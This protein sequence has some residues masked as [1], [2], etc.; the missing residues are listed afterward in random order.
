MEWLA[1]PR[2][3]SLRASTMST[4]DQ[5]SPRRAP[6]SASLSVPLLLLVVLISAVLTWWLWPWGNAGLNPNAA[7]RTVSAR[8]D[9]AAF[10][11][12]SIQI[13]DQASPSLVQVTTANESG[14][15]FG[16]DVQ[17]VPRGVGSGFVWDQEGH[18]VTNYH[19]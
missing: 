7:L 15:F 1:W 17:Q 6:I 10:E 12:T 11:Q 13:Y 19:V 9:L 2:F 14:G 5:P 3:G 16:L 18:I 4:Y 8:G